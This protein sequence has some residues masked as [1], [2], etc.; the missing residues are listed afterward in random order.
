[1]QEIDVYKLQKKMKGLYISIYDI[2]NIT[3]IRCSSIETYLVKDC[4]ISILNIALIAAVLKCNIEDL[5]E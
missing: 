2:N 3:E 4:T 5:I 1:M